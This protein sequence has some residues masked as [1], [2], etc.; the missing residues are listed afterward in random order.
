MQTSANCN[1]KFRKLHFYFAKICHSNWYFCLPPDSWCTSHLWVNY[2]LPKNIHCACES[3][4]YRRAAHLGF[5]CLISQCAGSESRS[6]SVPSSELRTGACGSPFS[7]SKP[8]TIVCRARN[9][10]TQRSTKPGSR[11]P[12]A[13]L[14]PNRPLS[15]PC[16]L[17]HV[18]VCVCVIRQ[19]APIQSIQQ[20]S[21]ASDDVMSTCQTLSNLKVCL[22]LCAYVCVF[23]SALALEAHKKTHRILSGCTDGDV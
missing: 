9:E 20:H 8:P 15:S 19:N 12:T 11:Q 14:T 3:W 21:S 23:V 22:R 7:E 6:W 18:C 1:W 2:L 10:P 5:S 4:L 13:P 17:V 16:T